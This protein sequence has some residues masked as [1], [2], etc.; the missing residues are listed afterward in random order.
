MEKKSAFGLRLD[1]MASLFSMGAGDPDPSDEKGD[2]ERMAAL[3]QEHLA[4]ALAR[5]SLLL[6][7]LLMM[8]GQQDYDA[9]LLAGKSLGEVLLSPQ[10]DIALLQGIKD[11]S[12]RLSGTLDSE[13]EAVIAKTL[14]FAALASA[15]V[16]H[17]R[18]I[19]QS[20]YEKLEESFALLIEKKWMAEELKMLFSRAKH[21]CEGKR[22][23]E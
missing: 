17:D 15:L 12:K 9:R 6:D 7:A 14:Y 16:Y 11:C 13:A 21:I 4:S 1:Q 2:S 18:K 23:P 8:M 5:R 10:S 22:S 20:S 3:L 19:T